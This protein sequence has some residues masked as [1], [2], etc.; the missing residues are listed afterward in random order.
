MNFMAYCWEDLEDSFWLKAR[1]PF[2]TSEFARRRLEYKAAV[3]KKR[4]ELKRKASK[5]SPPVTI[6]SESYDLLSMGDSSLISRVN[7]WLK[8]KFLTTDSIKIIFNQIS[9][10]DFLQINLLH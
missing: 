4:E 9:L 1:S 8:L 2:N 5:A 6:D 7:V 10:Y 3:D